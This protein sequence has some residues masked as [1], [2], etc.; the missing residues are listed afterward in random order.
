MQE[1]DLLWSR[2]ASKVFN[3]TEYF[4]FWMLENDPH[5]QVINDEFY[6]IF[7]KKWNGQYL[8][9]CSVVRFDEENEEM[10]SNEKEQSVS[11]WKNEGG[12]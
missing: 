9:P 4:M 11:N 8:V 7:E 6:Q 3:G 2:V 12:K 10:L 5:Y 1:G